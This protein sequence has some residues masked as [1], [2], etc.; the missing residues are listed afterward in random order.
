MKRYIL[1]CLIILTLLAACQRQSTA[2]PAPTFTPTQPPILAI[3]PAIPSETVPSPTTDPDPSDTPAADYAPLAHLPAGSE[4]KISALQIYQDGSGWALGGAA[5]LP[6]HVLH[7]DDRAATWQELTPPEPAPLPG[8][9]EKS[10]TAYFYDSQHAWVTFSPPDP[11]DEA[12]QPVVWRTS[13]S[14]ATWQASAVLP[15][16][17][18]DTVYSPA[19]FFF[20]D[21]QHGWLMAHHGAAAGHTPVSIF[22]TTDSGLSWQVMARPMDEVSY[23]LHT[24]CQSGLLF[25][26]DHQTGLVARDGGPI[27]LPHVLRTTDAGVTWQQYD[28]PAPVADLHVSNYC[29][30]SS[31][32]RTGGQAAA[33]VMNCD[34]FEPGGRQQAFLY[35][36]QDRGGT[37]TWQA[38]PEPAHP[39]DW[40]NVRSRAAVHWLDQDTRWLFVTI[41]Y[42]V[43]GSTDGY[44]AT[45][46]YQTLDAGS[47][48]TSQGLTYWQGVFSFPDQKNGYAVAHSGMET[49]LV[50]TQDSGS[51]WSILTPAL[52]K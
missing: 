18:V 35:T 2:A 40:V 43:P 10:A 51:T 3:T 28:F 24:C 37:W 22:R 26:D 30:T 42:E 50:A 16:A 17:R 8:S 14:G 13:D 41:Y 6:T 23:P 48:W 11:S 49:A 34:S 52:V 29:T 9:P 33:L 45:Q 15:D 20:S 21:L 44:N 47:T 39:A 31:L 27:P 36:T 25:F 19:L 5:D 7:T 12:R 38:L 46:I 4:I 1:L 32:Q